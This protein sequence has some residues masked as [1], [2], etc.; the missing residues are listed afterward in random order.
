M[1]KDVCDIKWVETAH[2]HPQQRQAFPL[3][4][5]LQELHPVL[6]PVQA[7]ENACQLQDADQVPEMR[8][9]LLHSHQL[10]QT[11]AVLRLYPLPL[12]ARRPAAPS[13]PD[14]KGRQPTGVAPTKGP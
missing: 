1:R 14:T 3:R 12:Y 6:K 7:Q 5:L 11:Q 13:L 2:T 10:V 4:G 8:P 9:G